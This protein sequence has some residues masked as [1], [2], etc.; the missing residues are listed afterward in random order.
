MPFILKSLNFFGKNFS[1]YYYI[2]CNTIITKLSGNRPL[3]HCRMMIMNAVG[4]RESS[5]HGDNGVS[6]T[7]YFQLSTAQTFY[8]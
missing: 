4:K 8:S 1:F 2:N 5:T 6:T 7:K 3:D